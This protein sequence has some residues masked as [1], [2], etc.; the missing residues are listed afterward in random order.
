M[1]Y[2]IHINVLSYPYQCPILM[3]YFPGVNMEGGT[4]PVKRPGSDISE[5]QP[6]RNRLFRTLSAGLFLLCTSW[7]A[8]S[9]T[10]WI[11]GSLTQTFFLW[12]PCKIFLQTRHSLQSMGLNHAPH[13]AFQE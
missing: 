4:L 2:P 12:N 5:H 8:Y 6:R 9:L 3:R 13:L 11:T 7:K 10:Q 1:S